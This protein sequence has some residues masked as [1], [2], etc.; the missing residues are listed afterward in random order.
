MEPLKLLKRAATG[1]ANDRTI[2]RLLSEHD[3]GEQ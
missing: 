3:S 2:Q 1:L